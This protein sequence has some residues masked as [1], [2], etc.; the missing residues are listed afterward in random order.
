MGWCNHPTNL[1]MKIKENSFWFAKELCSLISKHKGI[2]NNDNNLL[3]G[4]C[5]SNFCD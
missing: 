4:A 5:K 3:G 1:H 2:S